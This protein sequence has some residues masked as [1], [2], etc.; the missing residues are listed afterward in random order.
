MEESSIY[1]MVHRGS[2][3]GDERHPLTYVGLGRFQHGM[4]SISRDTPPQMAEMDVGVVDQLL[5][6]TVALAVAAGG[7]SGC[8]SGGCYG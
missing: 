4:V 2:C 7:C 8:S 6:M 1:T 5:L 3:P